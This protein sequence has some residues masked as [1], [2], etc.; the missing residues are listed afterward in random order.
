MDKIERLIRAAQQG[1]SDAL[2]EVVDVFEPAI[3]KYVRL[4]NNDED[5]ESE[6]VLHLIEVVCS[7]ELSRLSATNDGLLICYVCNA[8]KNK[9]IYL[10]KK[11]RKIAITELATEDEEK[12]EWQ[13]KQRDNSDCHKSIELE[14]L[15]QR[16]LTSKERLCIE[17]IVI[18]GYTA[19]EV[20]MYLGVTKQA[21]N[22][23]KKRALSKLKS[24]L[25]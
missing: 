20:A 17:L 3:R 4:M 11:R 18:Q 1:D 25:C 16:T 15:L 6:I 22:Q 13:N 24:N 9:Y 19:A 5:F 10:S 8:L 7:M 14:D 23:C 2:L 21:V 12:F